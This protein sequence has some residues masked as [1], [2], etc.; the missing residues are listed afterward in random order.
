MNHCLIVLGISTTLIFITLICAL[1]ELRKYIEHN[2]KKQLRGMY[3]NEIVDKYYNH[4]YTNIIDM[5]TY[6]YTASY[7]TLM[8]VQ[9]RD[10]Q[11]CDN[12]DGSEEWLM[13]HY[14]DP[15]AETINLISLRKEI[16]RRVKTV[17]PDINIT[18]SRKNCCDQYKIT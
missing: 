13:R 3:I 5:K 15:V 6:G 4:I 12:Y 16:L 1:T 18:M 14:G 9:L 10:G 11:Q 7:F 17:F 2:D 8:C